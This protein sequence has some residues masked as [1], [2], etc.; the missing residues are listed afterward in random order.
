MASPVTLTSA[1]QIYRSGEYG[2]ANNQW[3]TPPSMRNQPG[4]TSQI[5]INDPETAPNNVTIQWDFP[6]STSPSSVWGYLEVMWGGGPGWESRPQLRT[7]VSNIKDFT[8]DYS[9]R[10]ITPG[11]NLL[12]EVWTTNAQGQPTTE[13]G[14][15]AAGFRN[16]PSFTYQDQY[17]TAGVNPNS[18]AGDAGSGSW[19][20][21]QL[22]LNTDQ[23]SGTISFSNIISEMVRRGLINPNDY[24]TGLEL[25]VEPVRGSGSMQVDKFSVFQELFTTHL[26]TYNG[27]QAG[28]FF[29]ITTNNDYVIN[30]GALGVGTSVVRINT[31]LA[32]TRLDLLGDGHIDVTAGRYGNIDLSNIGEIRFSDQRVPVSALS[33]GPA[34]TGGADYLEARLGAPEIH[35]GLGNDTVTGVLGWATATYLRGDEGDDSMIGGAGFDDINGN[36]GADTID[37]G[38]GGHDWLVGGRD[39]DRITARA[40]N[41]ILYGNVGDDTL[42]GGSGNDVLRGGQDNDNISGGDG[43]DFIAG[44]RGNDTVAGGAGADIFHIFNEAGL[45]RVIDFRMSDG[46]RVQ[47]LPGT[48]YTVTQSGADTVISLS[49]GA[50]MVLAGVSLSAGSW[51]FGA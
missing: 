14:V 7:Q 20:F 17:I 41:N 42:V 35:A 26:I 6:N 34:A 9:V 44:D 11:S 22:A 48:Q 43:A 15:V 23:L 50:Q 38:A 12:I 39:N 19:R 3:G 2:V 30:G 16:R 46:D 47:L 27:A 37:G 24:V 25:G 18:P 51:I 29:D 8:L 33:A 49:G 32:T 31:P 21:I 10:N 4:S 45:D 13:I 40:S 28:Q 36:M 1:N 5:T